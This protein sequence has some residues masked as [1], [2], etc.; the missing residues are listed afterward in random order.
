MDISVSPGWFAKS[1]HPVALVGMLCVCLASGCW[2]PFR[3]PAIPASALPDE[4]RT[5]YRTAG[6]P[7][8]FANLTIRMPPDYQIGP[9][10]VLEISIA[11]LYPGAEF[12]PLRAQ[13]MADG[14]ITLPLAPPIAVAGSNLSEAQQSIS[15][16]YGDGILKEPC[17]NVT[18]AEKASVEV[19]VLGEVNSAGVHTLPKYQNDVG[20]ALASAGGLSEDA[21]D[22]IE[23]H[24]RLDLTTANEQIQRLGLEEFEETPGDPKKIVRI[25]LRGL[26]PGTLTEQDIILGPGDVIVVPSRKNEVFFVVGQLNQTNL[27]RFTLGD[28]ERELGTGLILPRDREI[29]VVQAV[30]MA[31]Y[32]DPINSPTTVTVQRSRPDGQPMLIRVNLIRAR[33][34]RRETVLVQPGDIIYVNPDFPWW[35]RRTLDRIVPDLLLIPYTNAITH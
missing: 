18:L 8:N 16:A 23:V 35:F 20:H 34:D 17:V 12:R 3:S 26:P 31:G 10:D 7:L 6:I 15:R 27:V 33:Y 28:R 22:L 32:I 13:V 29:D 2:A 4:Y 19:L 25:P 11:D 24:R 21:A 14:K 30:A 9:N 5:P 1:A